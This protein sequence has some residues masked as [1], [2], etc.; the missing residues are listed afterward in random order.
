MTHRIQRITNW[1]FYPWIFV[2]YPIL[3]L[4]SA[5]LALVFAQDVLETMGVMELAATAVFVMALV[6]VRDAYRAAGLTLVL[7][8]TFFTYGHIYMEIGHEARPF[9]LPVMLVCTV[10]VSAAVV[11]ARETVRQVSPYVNAITMVLVVLPLWSVVSY[12]IDLAREDPYEN[13][14]VLDRPSARKVTNDA[15]HPDI[16]YIILDAYPS[17]RYL[18]QQYGYDNSAFTDALEERGFFVAHDSRSNYGKTFA[19]LAS[20]LNMR[21]IDPAEKPDSLDTNPY[22]FSLIANN[23]VAQSLQERGYTYV[24]ILSG[25]TLPSTL[26]DINIEFYPNRTEYFSGDE[27]DL[28]ND[29]SWYYKQ[30]FWPIFLETTLLRRYA[31]NTNFEILGAEIYFWEEGRAYSWRSAERASAVFDAIETIPAMDEATFTFAH[32][33]KPH[34]P[35]VFDRDGHTINPTLTPENEASYFFEQLQ[36]VNTRTLAVIDTILEQSDTPPIIILQAD[37]GSNLGEARDS[38]GTFRNFDILN[39]YLFPELDAA[40]LATDITPV[41]SFRVMFNEYFG[42][43]YVMLPNRHFDIPKG[44]DDMF[45]YVEVVDDGRMNVGL[46]DRAALLYPGTDEAGKPEISVFAPGE[47]GKAGD[48]LFRIARDDV[49]DYANAPPTENTLVYAHDSIA[50][51]VLTTGE[52]Q[53]NIGPDPDGNSWAVIMDGIPAKVIYG[54]QVNR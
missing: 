34:E 38:N 51:Y 2:L 9:L 1:P 21:Y 33:M 29:G 5:N 3:H 24:D 6:L 30:S 16:Y 42:E 7:A 13:V 15:A 31:S 53:F 22:L 14:V 52:L 37:H 32:I 48:F 28:R 17:N 50:V 10:G 41:N 39:A 19:S 54:Y 18:L 11:C 27:I 4:F 25:Y 46:G 20:A 12:Y 43:S 35:V 26:A 49:A 47:D 23:Q 44:L 45:L 36:F 8:I 40:V